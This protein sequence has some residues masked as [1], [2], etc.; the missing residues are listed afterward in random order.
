MTLTAING[1]G[2]QGGPYPVVQSVVSEILTKFI[3]GTVGPL[4]SATPWV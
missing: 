3:I 2:P 4:L 1:Y